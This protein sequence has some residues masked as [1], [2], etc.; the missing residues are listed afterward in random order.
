MAESTLEELDAAL[1]QA[2]LPSLADLRREGFTEE[3][4]QKFLT[5]SKPTDSPRRSLTSKPRQAALSSPPRKR[6]G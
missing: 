6:P 5:G 3:Q 4:I 1:Q 2:G